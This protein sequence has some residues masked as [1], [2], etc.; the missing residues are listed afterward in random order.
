MILT[1]PLAIMKSKRLN[2]FTLIFCILLITVIS[3][4]SGNKSDILANDYKNKLVFSPGDEAKIEEAFL[5][6]KDSS[7]IELKAGTYAFDNL[8]LAQLKH[9]SIKGSGPDSSILDF[10]SQTQGGEGIRTTNMKDFCI[11]GLTIRNSKGD[12]IKINNSDNVVI[13]NLHA[14][15][16]KADSSNGGYAI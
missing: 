10:S 5:T 3:A 4:C 2:F 11:E 1:K 14:V 9:I 13:R 7:Q 6:L 16:T 15:W 12:L 8:S